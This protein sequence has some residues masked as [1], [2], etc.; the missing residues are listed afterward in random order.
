MWKAI[1][2]NM[3]VAIFI[4]LYFVFL[5]VGYVKLEEATYLMD[6]KVFSLITIG[7]TII[8]IEKSYKID[9][10][11]L[12]LFG[13]EALVLSICTLMTIFV[14][15]NYREKYINIMNGVLILF[16][17]YYIIKS[18]VIHHKMKKKA[19]QRASDIHKVGRMK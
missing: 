6:Q 16:V 19:L 17:V 1:I 10:D 14:I 4:A 9:S 5:N 7:I 8:I 13:I 11:E 2:K 18:I 15:N 12:A 3:L